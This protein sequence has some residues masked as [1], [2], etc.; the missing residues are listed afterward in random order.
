MD[1]FHACQRHGLSLVALVPQSGGSEFVAHVT[2]D[3]QPWVLKNQ[4]MDHACQ[5]GEVPTLEAWRE[6]GLAVQVAAVLEPGLLLLESLPGTTF[7][8]LPDGGISLLEPSGRVLAQLHCQPFTG[9]ISLREHMVEWSQ[10]RS[11][12]L[13]FQGLALRLLDEFLAQPEPPPVLLHGDLLPAN[14]MLVEGAIKVIDPFGLA[15]DAAFDIASLAPLIPLPDPRQAAARLCRG[16]GREVANLAHLL[17]WCL[18]RQWNF[19]IYLGA[20]AHVRRLT[21]AAD[22]L[23]RIGDPVQ[24]LAAGFDIAC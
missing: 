3:G 18:L 20:T 21:Q 10:F 23:L 2:R 19:A 5:P 13:R 12:D 9:A 1:P 16:Y 22:E 7:Y 8:D 17:A 6:T 15:G 24:W 14:I 4:A 11:L